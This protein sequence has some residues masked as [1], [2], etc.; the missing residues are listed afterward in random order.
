MPLT[1]DF[2]ETIDEEAK[3]SPEFRHA[4]LTEA[5]ESLLSG[6]LAGAKAILRSTIK[7]TI[8]YRALTQA[9]GIPEKSLIRM[10]GPGGNPRA[11]HLTRV[12]DA[13]QEYEEVRL[14]VRARSKHAA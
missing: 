7:A 10:F 4:L 1:R 5:V 2:Q 11:S 9:T 12:I 6:D 8:G 13:L 3:K 14:E